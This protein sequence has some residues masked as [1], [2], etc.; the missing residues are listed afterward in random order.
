MQFL[1]IKKRL[2]L[3]QRTFK[4]LAI[5]AATLALFLGIVIVPIERNTPG[6]TI[7]GLGDGLWWAVQTLTTVGYGDEV[8]VTVLGRILGATM[9][10]LGTVMFGAMIAMIS[11]SMSR[12]QEEFYW[13]RLFERLDRMEEQIDELQKKN[14]F[15]LKHQTT[16]DEEQTP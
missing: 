1:S 7:N 5:C 11:S 3:K 2:L 10:I 9:A 4:F 13:S 15:L 8:P 14:N 16:P 6:S 12:S